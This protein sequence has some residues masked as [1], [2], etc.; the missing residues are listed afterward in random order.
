MHASGSF[1]L[2]IR[3]VSLGVGPKKKPKKTAGLSYFCF[4]DMACGLGSN[5]NGNIQF[6]LKVTILADFPDRMH[7]VDNMNVFQFE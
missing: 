5:S 4:G 2:V 6:L 7:P 3:E 1:E